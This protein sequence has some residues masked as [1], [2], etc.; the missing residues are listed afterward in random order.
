MTTMTT[1]HRARAIAAAVSSVL[2]ALPAAAQA[3]NAVIT[4]KVT[5]E[6]GQPVEQANV[7]INDLTISVPTNAQGVYTITI[8]AARV[9][10]QQLNLRVRAIGYQPGLRPIRITAGSQTQDFTLR[11]DVNRLNEVVVTG[12]VGAGVERAK[13]PFAIGRLT[14]ED[15]PVPALDPVQALTG[16]VAGVRIGQVGGAPGSTPEIMLRGPHSI[17]AQGRSQQPLFVVDG[18]VLNVGS[19][20][21][22]G[23]LDIES[24][25]VVKGAAGASIYGATAANGVIVIKTKRGATQEGVKFTARTEYGFSDLNS[26]DYGQPI[27]H[28]LQLDETG[29]RFCVA[30]SGPVSPCSR[31]VN[32]MSEVMRINSVTTDTIRTGFNLQ[33]GQPG[34]GDL[35]NVFQANTWPGQRYNTMAQMSSPGIVALHSLDATGRVGGVRF[36]ASG[37]YSD[38]QGAVREL[39]GQQQRRARVNLDYD[40][41]S[42]AT[43]SISTM[44]DRGTTDLHGANFGGLLRG[45]TPGTNYLAR[46]TLGR[47]ILIGFGPASRP[48][49]N[50]NGGYFYNQENELL[51]RVSDRFLGSMNASYFPADWVTFDGTFGYDNRARIDRDYVAKG[52]RTTSISVN[53]NLGN[54]SI[55]NR[56]EEALNGDIGATFKHQFNPDLNGRLQTRGTYEQDILQSENG[57]GAQFIVKDVFTLSNTSTNFSVGSSGQTIKRMGFF[58]GANVE[59]KNRYI[60]DG[61]FRYDGSSLFGAG[62][63]W[64]PFGR[65]SGVWRLSEEPWFHVPHLSDFRLRASNGTA[66]NSPSFTAQYETYNCGNTGCTLGQA[67]NAALKPETTR[68]VEAGTDF[69]LFDRLGIEFTHVNSTTKNQIL[70]VPTAATLGFSTQWQNA[71][72]LASTTWEAAANLPVL[73]RRN[74]SW[75]MRGTW[76]RTRTFITELFEPDFF[77]NGGTGQGTGSLF[78][79]TAD[80][81]KQDGFQRNQFGN[82][83][84]R[85]FYKTCGD[86]PE[87]VRGQCGDGKAFQVNDQGWVV[88]VGAGN[89]WKDGITKNLWQTKLPAAQSPWNVPLYFGHPIVD[90]PLAG[91]PGEGGPVLH[92]LGNTLPAFRM[93]WNNTMQYKRLTWYVLLD[94]TYGHYI[95]NQGEQWGLLDFS[96]H[97]FDQADATVETAKPTGYGWRVG[98]PESSGSGG[99]YDV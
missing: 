41:K 70:P 18:A 90:R 29:T 71:G 8:P 88:W 97:H 28:S 15:M 82:I 27:N 42:T 69:T 23:G 20:D 52:Y 1:M 31:T 98:A 77:T 89:T 36:Y 72:T 64:A 35:L 84:G 65:V 5:S 9:S 37:S 75:T 25:E 81:T 54:A 21:E 10:G 53:T 49:G 22:L 39:T 7:Y 59:Y 12:T 2:L 95:N 56:R 85:K 67:G 32:W 63:R 60:L 34:G 96:S 94:G 58:S 79:M 14:A 46:D 40:V 93:T 66:G 83:W 62:N 99:F 47:P 68:E 92:I 44:Y 73:N 55:S 4:G 61:T 43:V 80:K 16:K 51:Y 38:D 13:V 45:A 76:D 74:F 24:V 11:Q 86:L 19:Y 6:F 91:Q 26:F 17:N 33:Y 48:T 78:F 3:Q 87:S 57:N 30:G 50:G